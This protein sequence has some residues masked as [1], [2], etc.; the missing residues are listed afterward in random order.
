MIILTRNGNKTTKLE[1]YI[2]ATMLV[3][4]KYKRD[5]IKRFYKNIFYINILLLFKLNENK[6]IL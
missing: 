1:R 2:V 3:I 5:P 4:L 6:F